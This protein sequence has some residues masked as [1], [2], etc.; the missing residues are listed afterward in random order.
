M[1]AASIGYSPQEIAMSDVSAPYPNGAPCWVDL[2]ASDRETAVRFYTELFG[3]KAEVGPPETGAYTICTIR[4]RP[5]AGIGQ[6]QAIGDKPAPP[7][8][9]TTYLATDDADA[10]AEKATAAGGTVLMGP[11]DIP[12]MG[13]MLIAADPTGAVFGAWQ[14]RDFYGAQVVD[15]PGALCWNEANTRDAPAA[16]RFYTEVFDISA[17]PMEGLPNY[18]R[19][20]AKGRTIGGIQQMGPDLPANIAPHWMSYFA[21]TDADAVADSLTKAGGTVLMKPFNVAPGRM[22]VLRDPQGAVFSV[23]ALA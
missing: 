6:A 23:I 2:M 7:V 14:A 9:W 5:V 17:E 13:R 10:T 22:A 4:D 3:W 20:R 11:T 18:F 16:A 1:A 12:T 19:L 15:E 21:V 8:A